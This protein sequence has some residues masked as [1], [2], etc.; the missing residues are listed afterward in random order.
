MATLMVE[1]M[2]SVCSTRCDV[3]IVAT[4]CDTFQNILYLWLR[5][6]LILFSFWSLSL[7]FRKLSLHSFLVVYTAAPALYIQASEAGPATG[8]AAYQK[9]KDTCT[10]HYAPAALLACSAGFPL[11][12]GIASHR[13]AFI[14]A[15]LRS[16]A[17]I[18]ILS[19]ALQPNTLNG[20]L[21]LTLVHKTVVKSRGL[22]VLQKQIISH[23]P[24]PSCFRSSPWA[25]AMPRLHRPVLG[26]CFPVSPRDTSFSKQQPQPSITC[27]SNS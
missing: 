12:S 13:T 17:V 21:R 20:W 16:L 26:S 24:L 5:F 23:Q 15:C 25:F 2:K 3:C 27:T 6:A 10:L 8:H 11:V 22:S 1:G 7:E 4:A 9:K 14:C 18:T 19:S